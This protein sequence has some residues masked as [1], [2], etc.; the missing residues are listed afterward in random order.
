M[1]CALFPTVPV[2]ALT[3]IASKRDREIIKNTLHMKNVMDVVESP[4]RLNIFYKKVFS[5]GGQS[6]EACE[7]I[8]QPV[9]NNLL[10]QRVQHPINIIYLH[11]KW[12]G[13][14]YRLFERVLGP[15]QY[16]PEGSETI[17]KSRIFAQFHAPQTVAM[18][19][20]IIKE[21]LSAN[22]KIR[23]FL[24]LLQWYGC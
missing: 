2:L 17:P 6:F 5:V 13:F 22:S 21:L 10:N 14:A 9:A 18:N 15:A 7:N 23:V 20:Q 16:Y 24:Q 3:P 19:D 4:D 12:C 1:L 8:L 11:L